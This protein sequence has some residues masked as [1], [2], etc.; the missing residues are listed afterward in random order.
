[1]TRDPGLELGRGE[2]K[3]KK[4]MTRC[5]LADLATR[6]TRKIQSKTW[7]QPVDFCFVF[8][9]KQHRFDIFKK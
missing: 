1:L 6:L 5:N 9:L 3:I 4:V 2:E 7:L 8:L